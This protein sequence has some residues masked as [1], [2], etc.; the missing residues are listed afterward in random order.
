M[1]RTQTM[2]QLNDELLAA[3]DREAERSGQSRSALI[4]TAVQAFLAEQTRAADIE[5]YVEGYRATPQGVVDDW[6]DLA[7]DG[8]AAGELSRRLDAEERERGLEW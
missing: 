6:G 5:R 7:R 4:R 2:V 8:A 1:A 3:L